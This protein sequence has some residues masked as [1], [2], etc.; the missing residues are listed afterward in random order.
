M[1]RWGLVATVRAPVDEIAAFAAWH[2]ELG[3]HRVHLYLDDADADQAAIL[4]AHPRLRVTATDTR[5]WDRRGGRPDM[6]QVRQGANMRHA[7]NRRAETD[8]LAHIDV[9]EFLMP[10]S[11]VADQ[12]AA[13]PAS[14]LCARVRPM[15]ALAPG[16]GD[17]PG[18]RSF[19]RLHLDQRARARAT[20]A[21]FP[22]WADHLSGGF[23]SHVAGKLF[24]RTGIPGLR[25]RIHN[26]IL[27]GVQNPGEV[28][29]AGTALAHLH[30]DSWDRFHAAYR[31]RRDRGS[32]RADLKPQARGAGAL[33]LHDLFTR[34]E[35]EAGTAGL[36]A[37]H[38]EVATATP[39][40]CA[41]LAA[42]GLLHRAALD[43]DA[44]RLRHFPAS[45]GAPCGMQSG[46]D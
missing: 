1:T 2:L 33:S 44:A 39:E 31:F 45:R 32:Y 30:A 7:L 11:P 5:F 24:V 13:L 20:R 27:D 23:L 3:A 26:A 10:E 19:K 41:A 21:C 35:A 46:S 8:W 22:R 12:L 38:R 15:E 29:L 37:F 28:A 14:A 42:E 9:D 6:H 43:L 4:S 16:A 17:L 25:V 40:L 34:I 18:L 36:Q